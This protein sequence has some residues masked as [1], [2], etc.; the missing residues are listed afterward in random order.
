MSIRARAELPTGWLCGYAALVPWIR[1]RLRGA[2]VWVRSDDRGEPIA[3]SDGRVDVLYQKGGKV[4][5]AA[6]R[7]L[8][9]DDDPQVISDEQAAPGAPAEQAPATGNGHGNS[10]G[11][12]GAS[13]QGRGGDP[14]GPVGPGG[15]AAVRARGAHIPDGGLPGKGHGQPVPDDAIHVYTDGACTGNP[16]PMGIGVVILEGKRRR[17]MSEFLGT[18]TNNVAELTAIL[19]GLSNV[20]RDRT[21]LVYSDSSY[22]L[23]LLG[24]GWRAKANQD[25]VAELRAVIAEFQDLRLVKVAGHAGV[26]ENER[27]DELARLA[28]LRQR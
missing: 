9:A 2:R 10:G 18:G 11:G 22:A 19:R 8:S 20:P 14:G 4:Y 25:L 1:K 26:A 13:A 6:A 27:C 5:R 28:A 12:R 17:E 16:G 24:R 3:G 21:V 15:P 23:G 7:N